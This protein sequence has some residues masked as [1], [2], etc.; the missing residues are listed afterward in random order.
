MN[1]IS[2]NKVKTEN[3]KSFSRRLDFYWKYIAVYALAI[4]LYAL[5]KGS[6]EDRTLTVML[7]DPVVI[8]LA[9][10]IFLTALGLLIESSKKK[11]II[12]GNDFIV[13]SNRFRKRTFTKD[14]IARI[15]IGREHA[16]YTG[17]FRIIKIKLKHR[18]RPVIIRPSSYWNEQKLISRFGKLK[19]NISHR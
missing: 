10:F 13:F 7:V 2:D 8:L 14:D 16:K 18:K 15:Y 1:K 12:V 4:I 11:E 19:R 3:G 5:I 9:V 6:F 17:K